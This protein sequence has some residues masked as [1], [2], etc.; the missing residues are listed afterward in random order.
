MS[1]Y[2]E[3]E[4][5]EAQLKQA[6]DNERNA[7]SEALTGMAEM[8]RKEALELERNLRRRERM[9]WRRRSR[10]PSRR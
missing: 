5:I 3:V 6:R 4:K 1:V 7:R 9:L 10:R 2:E 8:Y